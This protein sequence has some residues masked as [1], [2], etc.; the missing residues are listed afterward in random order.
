MQSFISGSG[1]PAQSCVERV[2]VFIV[3]VDVSFEV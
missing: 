1:L 2:G 3:N